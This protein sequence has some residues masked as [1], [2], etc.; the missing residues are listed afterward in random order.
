MHRGLIGGPRA[1]AHRT[2]QPFDAV[3]YPRVLVQVKPGSDLREGGLRTLGSSLAGS[4]LGSGATAV[5]S[6]WHGNPRRLFDRGAWDERL[7]QNRS[8]IS[9]EGSMSCSPW[10]KPPL[11]DWSPVRPDTVAI[12]ATRPTDPV[13]RRPFFGSLIGTPVIRALTGGTL[14]RPEERTGASPSPVRQPPSPL[15]EACGQEFSATA[16]YVFLH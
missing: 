5:V 13:P 8:M 14:D 6:I 2:R 3:Y 7:P 11:F 15:R 9:I 12:L 16:L 10:C 4:R 1:S